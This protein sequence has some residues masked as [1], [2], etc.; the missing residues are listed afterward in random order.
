MGGED[1]GEAVD[2]G[3][4]DEEEDV[5]ARLVR[6]LQPGPIDPP[7]PGPL[8]L[9]WPKPNRDFKFAIFVIT[10]TFWP[11]FHIFWVQMESWNKACVTRPE[12]GQNLL[13]WISGP[14]L[15]FGKVTYKL[16]QVL[17]VLLVKS[18]G[19]FLYR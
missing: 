18:W 1:E 17:G 4:E 19:E 12:P 13:Y 10:T 16:S 7:S 14:W 11:Y 2:E 15:Q 9:Q 5:I 3:G 8:L 6:R